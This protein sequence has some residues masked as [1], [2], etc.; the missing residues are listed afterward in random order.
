M[1]L[2]FWLARLT[3]RW[4]LTFNFC[5]LCWLAFALGI[6]RKVTLENLALALPERTPRERWRIARRNYLH[7]GKC[8]ADFL[9]AP[10]LSREALERLVDAGDWPIV[11]PT[12]ESGKGFIVAT[13]HFG[14]FEV[15]A[16]YAAR[17]VRHLTVLTRAL[18]GR[19]NAQ[20]VRLREL[21]G[22]HELHGGYP[23]L[24]GELEAGNAMALVLDQNLAAHRSIFVP[25]FG[26]EAATTPAPAV[27]AEQ[28]GAPIFLVLLPRQEDGTYRFTAEGPFHVEHHEDSARRE[29]AIRETTR[30]MNERFEVHVRERPEQWFWMHRRW[31]TRPTP[32]EPLGRVPGRIAK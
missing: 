9:R 27:L 30:L 5:A 23:N 24:L 11:A 6:R 15:L 16:I 31:K 19:F 17:R 32:E 20:W 13:A 26:R 8:A 4:L 29:A 25:F 18:K 21:M 28:S 7:L 3:P 2:I 1:A 14:A 22:V 10:K 12:I